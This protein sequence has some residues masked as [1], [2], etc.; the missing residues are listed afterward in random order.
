[1][2]CRTIAYYRVSTGQQQESGLG[3]KGQRANVEAYTKGEGCECIGEYN[4]IETGTDKQ[5]R[6]MLERAIAHAKFANAVLVIAKMDR[7]TRDLHFLTCL[8]KSK[9]RFHAC[10]MPGANKMSIRIM[11]MVAEQEA[12]AIS[13]RTRDALVAYRTSRRVSKRVRALYPDGVPADVVEAT[14]GK[15]GASLP[16][17]RNL[18]D[19]ARRKGGQAAGL[20]HAQV[21]D[22]FNAYIA[23]R[24]LEL[25]SAGST[26]QQIAATL[27][28]EGH[29]TRRGKSWTHVQVKNIVDRYGKAH[30]AV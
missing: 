8:E 11:V 23:P 12:E 28:A 13:T 6:P 15:L 26:L 19:A 9:V 16:Q 18:D 4:E 29:H 1:M 22:E 2:S 17:C 21:A 5:A 20:V 10:D 24:I 25:R 3:L 27:N 30:C 7:L 14:A